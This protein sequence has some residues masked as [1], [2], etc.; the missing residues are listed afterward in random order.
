MIMRRH[1]SAMI[2]LLK[3]RRSWVR[4]PSDCGCNECN[5]M[6]TY[7]GRTLPLTYGVWDMVHLMVIIIFMDEFVL[8]MKRSPL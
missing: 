6:A 3:E 1:G 2:C 4:S 8:R 5:I 7:S